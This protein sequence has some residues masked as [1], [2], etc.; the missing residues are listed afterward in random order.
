M[1]TRSETISQLVRQAEPLSRLA[2]SDVVVKA[3]DGITRLIRK[4][5][6]STVLGAFV[7]G[8]GLA[9]LFRHLSED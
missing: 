9:R 5:P 3:S 2:S 6:A 4:Y 7:V 8:F 1:S